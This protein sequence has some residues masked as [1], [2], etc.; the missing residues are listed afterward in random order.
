MKKNIAL[1][2]ICILVLSFLTVSCGKDETSVTKNPGEKTV[3]DYTYKE[4]EVKA[5]DETPTIE[6][7]LASNEVDE[8]GRA[9]V[10]TRYVPG[11]GAVSI[12]STLKVHLL[13]LPGNPVLI[14]DKTFAILYGASNSENGQEVANY[15]KQEEVE[16]LKYMLIPSNDPES[17][18]GIPTVLSEIP[19]GYLCGFGY[20]SGADIR[21]LYIEATKNKAFREDK[22][23]GAIW[24]ENGT[25]FEILYPMSSDL[26]DDPTD[27][28][29]VLRFQ[30]G[31]I[32]FLVT[33][34][35][36]E[37]AE[38]KMLE[39]R[40]LRPTDIL[41]AT[42]GAPEG[43]MSEDF[44]KILDPKEIIVGRRGEGE[45]LEAIPGDPKMVEELGDI[46]MQC[47]GKKYSYLMLPDEEQKTP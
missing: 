6:S 18:G 1:L 34:D 9:E 38:R 32:S 35:I 4:P 29:M 11:K 5:V 7:Q 24:Y 14:H 22:S 16:G 36:S 3:G 13:D 33:G 15:L 30:K 19:T 41:I 47:N 28:T 46:V 20:R 2:V 21:N 17:F 39:R 37:K 31:N 45:N 8:T 25:E 23:A 40:K 26:T 10:D 44:L 27:S 43:S 42:N 12:P